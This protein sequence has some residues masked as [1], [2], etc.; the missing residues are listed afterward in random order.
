MPKGPAPEAG[1]GDEM[2]KSELRAA[3]KAAAAAGRP[4]NVE[5]AAGGGL[6]DVRERTPVQERRHA[7]A[8]E[9]WARGYDAR[10]GAPEGDGDR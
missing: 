9:R 10:N 1:E 7:R 2:T 4:W 8:M 6:E 5:T 3:R